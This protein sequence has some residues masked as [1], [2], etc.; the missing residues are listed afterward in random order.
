MPTM[1]EPSSD[2]APLQQPKAPLP[3]ARL[4]IRRLHFE[5]CFMCGCAA[6]PV[7]RVRSS[8]NWGPLGRRLIR[9]SR[10]QKLSNTC[11]WQICS[12]AGCRRA[13]R[14]PRAGCDRELRHWRALDL[15]LATVRSW[16]ALPVRGQR[17]QQPFVPAR[18]ERPVF[19]ASS[20][21]SRPGRDIHTEQF[22]TAKLTVAS[23]QSA[24]AHAPAVASPDT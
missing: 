13:R 20:S 6:A 14:Q 17:R 1:D 22:G 8:A 18:T 5:A 10:H 7:Q 3:L 24:V 23:V 12:A 16:P 11:L 15:P 2:V 19:Q 9:R 4:P 21:T